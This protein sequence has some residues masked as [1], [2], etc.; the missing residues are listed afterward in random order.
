MEMII[1]NIIALLCCVLGFMGNVFSIEIK[2]H[3][4]ENVFWIILLMVFISLNSV[5]LTYNIMS[6]E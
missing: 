6:L 5:L 3:N 2:E 4:K 1:G